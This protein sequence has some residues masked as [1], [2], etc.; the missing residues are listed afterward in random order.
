MIN[1]EKLD[2]PSKVLPIIQGAKAVAAW[3][4]DVG[5]VNTVRQT[6]ETLLLLS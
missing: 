5:S 2:G 4:A 3:S 1:I 6:R